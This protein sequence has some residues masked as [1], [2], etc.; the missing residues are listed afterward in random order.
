MQVKLLVI[1]SVLVGTSVQVIK[2][3][4]NEEDVNVWKGM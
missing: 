1:H 3:V 2:G 4:E